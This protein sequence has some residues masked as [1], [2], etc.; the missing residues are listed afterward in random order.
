[1][2]RSLF[3]LK[4]VS[5]RATSF[6][7]DKLILPLDSI[8]FLIKGSAM[9]CISAKKIWDIVAFVKKLPKMTAEQYKAMDAAAGPDHDE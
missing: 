1:M 8:T 2:R 5:G 4:S 6:M 3:K 7:F 9:T